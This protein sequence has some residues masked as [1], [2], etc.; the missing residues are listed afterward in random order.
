M[1][2]D[3]ALGG[4]G[5]RGPSAEPH[6]ATGLS[7]GVLVSPAA[8][9]SIQGVDV[10]HTAELR[11]IRYSR[12]LQQEASD[13]YRMLTPTLEMLVRGSREWGRCGRPGPPPRGPSRAGELSRGQPGQA[14]G[15]D[16]GRGR[17]RVRLAGRAGA[18]SGAGG[19]GV[20]WS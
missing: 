17:S 14:L 10:E 19:R 11:G 18:F 8:S 5:P 3:R 20:L 6:P 15:G 13:Y 12:S 2:G 7:H 1:S 4:G 9:L 16:A